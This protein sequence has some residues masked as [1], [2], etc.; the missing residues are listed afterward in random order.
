MV[1]AGQL[2]ATIEPRPF[3]LALM[4]AQAP[5]AEGRGAA[6]RRQRDAQALPDA[7][8]A[9]LDRAPGRRHP[10]RHRQAAAGHR[11]GRPGQRGH[12]QAQPRVDAHHRAGQRPRGPALGRHR[13]PRVLGH[14]PAASPPSPSSRRSTSSSRSR[15]T[16]SRS[17]RRASPPARVLAVS[18]LDRT[19]TDLLDTGAFLSL[20]NQSDTQTG[21][22]RAKARFANAQQRAV[23]EPV[24]QRAHPARHAQGRRRRAGHGAAPRPE[25]RLRLRA[26]RR[27]HRHAGRR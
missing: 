24:R 4:Q 2:L 23:P 1:K 18:A 3:E 15:R 21:T 9:G 11:A 22:V 16:A 13:Q 20:N 19:R 10:G 8:A 25:R 6:G 26:R 12:R 7:A 14:A 17:C 5:A 27:P